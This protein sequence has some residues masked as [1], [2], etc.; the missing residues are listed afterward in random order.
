[1]STGTGP[2]YFDV[3][4]ACEPRGG[5]VDPAATEVGQRRETPAAGA[6][7]AYAWPSEADDPVYGDARPV[8]AAAPH[9][10]ASSGLLPARTTLRATGHLTDDLRSPV[11]NGSHSPALTDGH[12]ATLYPALEALATWSWWWVGSGTTVQLVGYHRNHLSGSAVDMLY[13]DSD[14]HATL[15]RAAAPGQL[16]LHKSGPLATVLALLECG[17]SR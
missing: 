9:P 10:S 5:R 12:P 16:Y 3:L 11:Q 8:N 7:L 1:M 2:A 13:I 15:T 6:D 4:S 14:E 17:G